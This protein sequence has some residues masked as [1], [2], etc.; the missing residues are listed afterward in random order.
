VT[1]I[2]R[3]TS[4]R[5]LAVIGVLAGTVVAARGAE[6]AVELMSLTSPVA[7]F[8]D[9]RLQIRT[10]PDASCMI[11]VLYASG[12]SR[13]RGLDTRTA[14]ANGRVVWTW[15]VGSSTTPGR[16]PRALAHRCGV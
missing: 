4:L 5:L 7:P 13:A 15:R 11:E 9:A 12:P 2:V 6:L 3:R 10:R 8:S 16:W 14:D 1:S